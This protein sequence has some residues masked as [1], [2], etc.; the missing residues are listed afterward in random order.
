MF[1]YLMLLIAGSNDVI[2]QSVVNS[3]FHSAIRENRA[4]RHMMKSLMVQSRH[5]EYAEQEASSGTTVMFAW[6]I[7]RVTIVFP[8]C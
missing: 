5:Q 4:A 3:T 6:V 2:G 8:R 1:M 7:R